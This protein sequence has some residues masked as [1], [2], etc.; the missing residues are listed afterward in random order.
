MNLFV[1]FISGAHDRLIGG[2]LG[3]IHRRRPCWLHLRS[4]L[5]GGNERVALMK[6]FSCAAAFTD[7]GKPQASEVKGEEEINRLKTHSKKQTENISL[8]FLNVLMFLGN[9]NDFIHVST[10]EVKMNLVHTWDQHLSHHV[11][12]D[13]SSGV[14]T[15]E[16]AFKTH[17]NVYLDQVSIN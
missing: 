5:I 4:Q 13:L 11:I 7:P 12:I 15:M 9:N 8:R 14:N 6:C 10:G 3:A 17:L 16:D 2:N 1:L